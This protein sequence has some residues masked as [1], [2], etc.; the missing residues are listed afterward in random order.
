MARDGYTGR[1]GGS[2]RGANGR[3]DRYG[4][5]RPEARGGRSRAQGAG[6]TGGRGG[7]RASDS[8]YGSGRYGG[9]SGSGNGGSGRTP[10]RG[11]GTAP[12]VD[13]L[14]SGMDHESIPRRTVVAGLL[15]A[16]VLA[17][18]GQLLDYQV[19]NAQTYRDRADERRVSSQ[20]LFAKRGTIYDRNG[21]V[22]AQS[23][24]CENVYANPKL[25]EDVDKAAKALV[26]V[27]GM[28]EADAREKLTRDKTFVYL[29]RQVNEDLA[30]ELAGYKL[31]GIE[32]EPSI[33]RVYPYGNLASQILGVVNIDNEGI[34]G[35]EAQYNDITTYDWSKI[36]AAFGGTDSNTVTLR[37]ATVREFD[38]AC[39]LA[40]ENR[41]KPASIEVVTAPM[42]MPELLEKFGAQAAQLN[43]KK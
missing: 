7:Y 36:P 24:E 35:L 43:K 13:L 11:R 4:D 20:T 15:G 39:R 19:V 16:G 37:A 33:M 12:R 22:I 8:A 32:F 41:D 14:H 27:L 42:D 26:T 9:G 29:K 5:G 23:V 28:D 17:A 30:T 21:N 38:E 3:S 25:V 10:G 40:T 1:G 18:V 2:R 6:R 31:K 34:S